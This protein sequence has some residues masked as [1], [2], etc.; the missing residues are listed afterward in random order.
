MRRAPH[1]YNASNRLV[2]QESRPH[3]LYINFKTSSHPLREK[4]YSKF[5]DM[6]TVGEYLGLDREDAQ[7]SFWES[8]IRSKFVLSPPG[9]L[10][11]LMDFFHSHAWDF[12][13]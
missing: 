11:K 8:V 9:K 13:L 12:A 2:A 6:G 3:L 1:F 7:A 5:K 10:K 4:V